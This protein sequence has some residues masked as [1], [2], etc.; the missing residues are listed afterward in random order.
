MTKSFN[1]LSNTIEDVFSKHSKALAA[2][3]ST[4]QTKGKQKVSRKD[5]ELALTI[6]LVELATADQNF[7][8]P[9]YSMIVT[10]LKRIFGTDR[11]AVTGLVNQANLILGNLRGSSKFAELL[12]ENLS[13]PQR[14]CI[15][16][17]VHEIIEADGKIDGYELYIQNRIADLLG[18]PLKKVAQE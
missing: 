11:T 7:D 3:N 2:F 8:T 10:G 18:I 5:L 15:I 14:E 12:R 1:L 6:L 9:E 13:I 17:I 4:S 16:E